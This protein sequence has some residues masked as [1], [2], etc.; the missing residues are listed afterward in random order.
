MYFILNTCPLNFHV[1][2]GL[3]PNLDLRCTIELPLVA[4][5]SPKM[6]F[7]CSMTYSILLPDLTIFNYPT[8]RSCLAKMLSSLTPDF[9]TWIVPSENPGPWYTSLP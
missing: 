1:N 8:E 9:S 5:S 7:S 4:L 6:I 2:I 3:P